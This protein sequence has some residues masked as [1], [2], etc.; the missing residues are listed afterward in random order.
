[1]NKI[2]ISVVILARNEEKD[3]P[4]CLQSLGWCD[5]IHVINNLSK[6]KTVDVAKRY[7]TKIWIHKLISFGKQMNWALK[8]CNFKYDWIL[9]LDADERSTFEFSRSLSQNIKKADGSVAGF[10]CCSKTIFKN[11][12]LK[13][14]DSFPKWRF[15]LLKKGNAKFTDFGH[16][17]KEVIMKGV[18][19]YIKEPYLHYSFS[20][21]WDAWKKKQKG[22]AKNETVYRLESKIEWK[23]IFSKHGSIRNKALKPLMSR[24][25]GWP[26]ARF[27]YPYILRLGFLEGWPAF[28]YCINLAKIELMIQIDMIKIGLKKLYCKP[29]KKN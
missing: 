11:V 18:V 17:P 26:L 6:D 13:R 29:N 4:G 28:L 7:K 12:W 15:R 3:L 20:K 27:V 22:Y 8:K 21:G 24:I 2:P 1:M 25:P 16:G 9:F 14:S 23:N 10:Y 19:R 5:D